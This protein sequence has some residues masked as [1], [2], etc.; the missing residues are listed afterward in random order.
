MEGCPA[1][2][3]ALI[4]TRRAYSDI[5]KGRDW[6]ERQA[7]GL[8]AKFLAAVTNTLNRIEASPDSYPV[9]IAP[10]RRLNVQRFPY[11]VW[12]VAEV[13]PVVIAVLHH[14]Q[15]PANIVSSLKP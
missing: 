2:A 13:E 7:S 6:Y 1:S 11:G 12:Y 10:A 4:L 9:L 15:N 3:C 8:G 14:R 5:A